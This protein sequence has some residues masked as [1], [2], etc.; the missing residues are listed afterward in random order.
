MNKTV[1]WTLIIVILLCLGV[2]ILVG[3]G[4]LTQSGSSNTDEGAFGSAPVVAIVQPAD[5]TQMN[6]GDALLVYVTAQSQGGLKQMELLIDGQ[7]I[8]TFTLPDPSVTS[9]S[10]VFVVL[11]QNT[12]WHEITARATNRQN[13]TSDS[14]AI[15]VAVAV[16]QAGDANGN[17]QGDLPVS[18]GDGGENSPAGG[19]NAGNPP[20]GDGQANPPA[21]G[22]DA[23][24][25]PPAGDGQANPPADG[26]NP[27]ADDEALPALPPQ[28]NDA[29]PQFPLY[30]LH[31]ELDA[32]GG[33]PVPTLFAYAKAE[34]DL[35][36]RSLEFAW[37]GWDG[38]VLID[39]GTNVIDCEGQQIC[40]IGYFYVPLEVGEYWVGFTAKDTSGHV[41]VVIDQL[42]VL[43][44]G[45]LPPA[46]VEPE[47]ENT[48][49]DEIIDNMTP[50]LDGSDFLPIDPVLSVPDLLDWIGQA[51]AGGDAQ[52]EDVCEQDDW[53]C[54]Y[55]AGIVVTVNSND[56][57][58][59]LITLRLEQPFE[60]PEG[61]TLVPYIQRT[62]GNHSSS[63]LIVPP[64]WVASQGSTLNPGTEFSYIDNDLACGDVYTYIVGLQAYTPGAVDAYLAGGAYPIG[65]TVAWERVQ[66]NGRCT[67]NS[68]GPLVL[69][70]DPQPGGVMLE[71]SIPPGNYPPEGAGVILYRFDRTNTDPSVLSEVNLYEEVYSQEDLRPGL[72]FTDVDANVICGHEY[73]Y[74]LG[75]YPANARP[76]FSPSGWL[77]HTSQ[78]VVRGFCPTD[79][80]SNIQLSLEP[81]WAVWEQGSYQEVL[82]TLD[83]PQGFAWPAGRDVRLNIWQV[84]EDGS[85]T[86]PGYFPKNNLR[87]HTFTTPVDCT[88]DR[89]EFFLSLESDGVRL[90]ET[91]I[92]QVELEDCAPQEPPTLIS[93]TATNAC[94]G[95][96]KCLV[97]NWAPYQASGEPGYLPVDSIFIQRKRLNAANPEWALVGL[98]LS[99]PTDATS[100]IDT[101]VGCNTTYLYRM[102]AINYCGPNCERFATT[103][104][105]NGTSIQIRTPSCEEPWSISATPEGEA[106]P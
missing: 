97:I 90:N 22:G 83:L 63:Q 76:G 96:E 62:I 74:S 80:L 66:A 103:S 36:L 21:G 51:N 47:E 17:G 40:E 50:D 82:I 29:P 94:N 31:I 49:L 65:T 85:A 68:P 93:V 26:E 44:G 105:V 5:K 2:A 78:T 30:D 88:Q 28:P 3:I 100:Y 104:F 69:V 42:Q 87:H 12:G 64:N 16:Q 99:V 13:E 10:R 6:S 4:Y 59:N 60:A 53:E 43:P 77:Q 75:V 23:G 33:D 32:S 89:A 101:E 52:V 37:S 73:I 98:P 70:T 39:R 61:K 27:G 79:T 20:A 54:V 72:L 46:A 106:N 92:Y 11:N 38:E 48:I 8:Q 55:G 15:H 14:N 9:V 57:A 91:G 18:I 56:P 84:M 95:A 25:N 1:V 24:N 45:N 71:W 67:P 41:S 102:G 58:G 81:N 86:S 34:D 19:D 35:G 7:V